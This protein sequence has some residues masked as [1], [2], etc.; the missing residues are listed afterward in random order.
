MK[1]M[2]E[3]RVW[4]NDLS[5][6]VAQAGMQPWVIMKESTCNKCVFKYVWAMNNT[7]YFDS[8]CRRSDYSQWR[9]NHNEYFSTAISY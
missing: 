5:L 7:T 4:A 8:Q 3:G 6:G 1:K 2:E 9:E